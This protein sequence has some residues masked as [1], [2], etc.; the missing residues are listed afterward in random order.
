MKSRKYV[1][2]LLSSIE[3]LKYKYENAKDDIVRLTSQVEYEQTIKHYDILM[4]KLSD[5]LRSL[6]I[7]Y[8]YTGKFYLKK[9]Y[10]IPTVFEEHHGVIFMRE[11]LIS[12]QIE[13]GVEPK[14]YSYIRTIFKEPKEDAAFELKR[15]DAEPV[16]KP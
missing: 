4:A 9:P 1:N 7:G 13:S 2:S 16:Y 10:V 5:E 6:P 3:S 8:R 14:I 11:D 15:E 12:W